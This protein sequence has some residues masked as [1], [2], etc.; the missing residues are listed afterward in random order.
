MVEHEH[1]RD[2]PV[3]GLHLGALEAEVD[4]WDMLAPDPSLQR[5]AVAG[6][7]ADDGIAP[8]LP[9]REGGAEAGVTV[10]V[11]DANVGCP[12]AGPWAGTRDR[13]IVVCAAGLEP[14]RERREVV[15]RSQD[16]RGSRA[17]R[18]KKPRCSSVSLHAN[19]APGSSAARNKARNNFRMRRR[20]AFQNEKL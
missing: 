1:G 5:L 11:V 4:H 14:E 15:V 3:H 16:R 6:R 19:A 20:R 7:F 18:E 17:L 12:R 2:D 13:V 8:A 10:A 9:D